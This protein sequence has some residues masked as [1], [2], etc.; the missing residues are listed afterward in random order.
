MLYFILSSFMGHNNFPIM[1]GLLHQKD[2]LGHKDLLEPQGCRRYRP[3]VTAPS[4]HARNTT[5]ALLMSS[6]I[7]LNN[8]PMAGSIEAPAVATGKFSVTRPA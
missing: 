7:L 6:C 5:A 3:V 1:Y 2:Q 4:P 8:A